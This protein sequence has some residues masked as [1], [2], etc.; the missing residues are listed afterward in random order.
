MLPAAL[1]LSALLAAPP[2]EPLDIDL[3]DASAFPTVV[4]DVVVPATQSTPDLTPEMLALEGGT[5]SAVEAIDPAQMAVSLVIDDGP[6]L[7]QDVVQDSQAASVELVRNLA[8]GTQ[9]GL[10]TPSG[11]S[12]L[13]TPDADANISR[14]SGIVAG[15]PD[16]LPLP[17]LV[18]DAAR[19]LAAAPFPDRHLVVI[20]GTT[21]PDGPILDE[22]SRI[23]AETGM[24]VH[25]VGAAD[26]DAGGI[27]RLADQSGGLNPVLPTP[28][29]EI[30]AV[31]RAIR[32]RIRAT[33]TVDGPGA[34]AVSLT[35][36][37]DTFTAGLDV[38]ASAAAP[39]TPAPSSPAQA[40]TEDEPISTQASEA[41]PTPGA[42][43]TAPG[44][45]SSSNAESDGTGRGAR[46]LVAVMLAAVAAGAFGTWA[47]LRRRAVRAA[48]ARRRTRLELAPP[49]AAPPP[50]LGPVA[51]GVPQPDET[52]PEGD[53]APPARAFATAVAEATAAD[54]SQRPDD[55]RLEAEQL[56]LATENARL[57]EGAR[58]AEEARRAEAEQFAS[59]KAQLADQAARLEEQR[60]T[61][62]ARLAEDNARLTDE[63]RAADAARQAD[64]AR[65]EAEREQLVEAARSAGADEVAEE[66]A[67]LAA[68]KARAR[69][70][71]A[72]RRA[73]ASVRRH[74]VRRGEGTAGR[75]GPARRRGQVGGDDGAGRGEGT[76]R[77]GGSPHRAGAAGGR[78]AD[79]RGE[80][81][82]RGRAAPGR[83]ESQ[84]RRGA[85]GAGGAAAGGGAGRRGRARGRCGVAPRRGERPSGRGGS[86]RRAGAAR[87]GRALGS[88]EGAARRRGAP[89]RG[90]ALRRGA[91]PAGGPE[92]ATR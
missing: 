23:V 72:R 11:L 87:R 88:G 48:A 58:A 42:A 63:A 71:A 57:T 60:I 49:S 46:W 89:G 80:G 65:F 54:Q 64:I 28:V 55:G 45:A 41:T 74:A 61:E 25:V 32:N 34:H 33:A 69:R 37:G 78:G 17:N 40:A 19:R 90:G 35:I 2:A 20:L 13:L 81:A 56:R 12:T 53:P 8:D 52:D 6:A 29:G 67:R 7:A 14:I 83:R 73:G 27:A 16:V 91:S 85:P 21:F 84:R 4:F 51:L 39:T 31:T 70:G 3:F 77:L 38:P 82:A 62:Q 79:R 15:A 26:L 44:A 30:D 76:A 22:L 92:G 75:C 10:S 24:H 36:G 9:V 5:V 50:E 47:V 59:E 1:A 68:E 86:R 18:L 66:R 43:T